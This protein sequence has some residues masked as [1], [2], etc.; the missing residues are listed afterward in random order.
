MV[1]EKMEL[2]RQ[3]WQIG[4]ENCEVALSHH[5]VL[6]LIEPANAWP[7]HVTGCLSEIQVAPGNNVPVSEGSR[8]AE[9][10][11][12]IKN[13]AKSA[14]ISPEQFVATVTRQDDLHVVAR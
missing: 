1:I 2:I 9:I 11:R 10:S 6:L 4:K 7:K 8:K 13:R 14:G 3:R 12:L 5:R